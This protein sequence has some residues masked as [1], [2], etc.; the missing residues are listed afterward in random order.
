ML[1]ICK[2]YVEHNQNIFDEIADKFVVDE[3][4]NYYNERLDEEITKRA[5]YSA[6]RANNRLGKNKKEKKGTKKSNNICNSYVPHMENININKDIIINIIN[7]LNKKIDSKY[8]YKTKSTQEYIN[9]RLK[10]GYTYDDFVTVIDKKY[11]EWKGTDFEKYLCPDTLFRPANFEKYLNQ[12]QS[13]KPSKSNGNLGY[14]HELPKL[15]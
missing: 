4:G 12:K 13:D 11:F 6:S 7:Y 9:A 15:E 5:N 1:I 14:S 3:Q 2:S 10:E 8:S